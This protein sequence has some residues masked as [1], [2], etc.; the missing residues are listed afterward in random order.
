ME[1]LIVDSLV[2]ILGDLP[3]RP[4]FFRLFSKTVAC[5]RLDLARFISCKNL[6][7]AFAQDGHERFQTGAEAANLARIDANRAAKL[8]LGQPPCAA[9]KEQMLESGRHHVR[10]RRGWAGEVDGIEL[11]V[12][13]NDAAEWIAHTPMI[14]KSRP[15]C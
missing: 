10:R 3:R 4:R 13:M 11:L 2:E 6:A 1:L 14:G 15:G 8:F 7:L 12:R 5:F 9:V